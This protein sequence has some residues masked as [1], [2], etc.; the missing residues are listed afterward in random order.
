MWPYPHI[1]AWYVLLA[2]VFSGIVTYMFV[3]GKRSSNK[4]KQIEHGTPL[5]S[6]E[7]GILEAQEA[8][9]HE[10]REHHRH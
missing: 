8:I 2:I 10:R 9:K 7:M 5:A 6:K 3:Y 4:Q 1:H